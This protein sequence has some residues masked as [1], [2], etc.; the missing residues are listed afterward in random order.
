MSRISR[1]LL[2]VLP[3][4][5]SSERLF[6]KATLIS[7][8]TLRNRLHATKVQNLLLLKANDVVEQSREVEPGVDALLF[9]Q[10]N[11]GSE[12]SDDNESG[13]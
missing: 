12:D 6:S 10:L 3:T 1:M 13:D 2:Y 7:S 11:D 4:S 9:P 5:V 8:N